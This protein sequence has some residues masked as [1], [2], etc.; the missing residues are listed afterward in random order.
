MAYSTNPNLVKARRDA[1]LSV[2]AEQMPICVVARHFGVHRSTIWR[3]MRKWRVLNQQ[4]D[5]DCPNR[6]NR[7]GKTHFC[8]TYYSWSIRTESSAPHTHPGRIK[9]WVIDRI[10]A[11]RATLG[12]CAVIIREELAKEQVVVSVSTIRRVIA[13]YSLQKT[14]RRTIRRT[15]PRPD[16]KSPGDLVQID[17]L[18]YVNKL[19]GKRR[20]IFTVID[21]YSRMSYAKCFDRLLPGNALTTVLSA[22]RYFGFKITTIQ[23]DNG[24]EFSKWFSHQL[25]GKGIVHRKIRIHRPN[26][27]A[28]IER[29]NRTLREECVGQHMSGNLRLPLINQKLKQYIDYY[30]NKRL[31]LGIQ[32]MTPKSMLQR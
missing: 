7:R 28:H 2:I 10:L 27:N 4:I 32:C 23:S 12:R 8:P 1:L 16:V 17:T 22:E 14:K 25:H 5:Q 21:L 6:P 29:F 11:I 30:N 9:Q 3:W 31:H 18:H 19:T 24:P 20:Y 13:K 15:L 26:D